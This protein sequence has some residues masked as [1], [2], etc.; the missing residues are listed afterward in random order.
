[1]SCGIGGFLVSQGCTFMRS[2][3]FFLYMLFFSNSFG[4]SRLEENILSPFNLPIELKV[5]FHEQISQNVVQNGVSIKREAHFI[6]YSYNNHEGNLKFF[7]YLRN[8]MIF[9]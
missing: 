2:L 1:M 6:R 4:S 3:V 5:L 8:I 9:F 7:I